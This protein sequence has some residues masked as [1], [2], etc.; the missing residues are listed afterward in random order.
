MA[1]TPSPAPGFD[2]RQNIS[3]FCFVFV[4]MSRKLKDFLS[5]R[6]VISISLH[7][8]LYYLMFLPSR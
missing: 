5:L 2:F 3:D 7:V 4:A 8:L 6:F 1:A